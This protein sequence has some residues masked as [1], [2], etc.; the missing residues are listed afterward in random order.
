VTTPLAVKAQYLLPKRF[1]TVLAGRI[2]TAS[3]G[4]LT[5]A[6]I[7]RYISHYG[8]DLSEAAERRIESYATFN[9]F[10][11]RRLSEGARPIDAAPFVCPVDGEISQ[12]GP[13]EKNQIFQAKG[14]SY[15][16][17]TLLAGDDALSRE[18]SN[19]H[20]ATLYLAPKDYHRVHMP[21]DGRLLRM[22]HVP[23]ELFSVNALTA[24]HVPGLFACNERVVCVF[25]SLHG[26]FVIVLVGA[27]IVGSV[28]T[29][30]HGIVNP[31]RARDIRNWHYDGENIVLGKGQE[32]GG[33]LVGST[34][35]LLF[36]KNVLCFVREWAPS[37]PVRLGQPM[38]TSLVD[39]HAD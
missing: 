9:E 13:I 16:V 5:R 36:P 27:T 25:Q 11:S 30:W 7:R 31:P 38:A 26:L 37:R 3:Y 14:H 20:F 21:C 1:L 2:A 33:F 32:M 24:L 17:R 34:V 19:G 4:V 8:V 6:A 29:A 12:F 10:F 15:D 35:I 23:G 39:S 28:Q 22:I 18:F